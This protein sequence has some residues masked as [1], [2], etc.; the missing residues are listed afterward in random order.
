MRTNLSLRRLIDRWINGSSG[1][2]CTSVNL[3]RLL[4]DFSYNF[5]MMKSY[6]FKFIIAFVSFSFLSSWTLLHPCTKNTRNVT[7]YCELKLRLN[8]YNKE[9]SQPPHVACQTIATCKRKATSNIYLSHAPICLLVAWV[10]VYSWKIGIRSTFDEN[11]VW[12]AE[13]TYTAAAAAA[14]VA[15]LHHSSC[16]ETVDWQPVVNKSS[17]TFK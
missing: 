5:G 7:T 4:N 8:K 15:L 6:L 14:A 10:S 17:P 11:Y 13:W 12:K 2:A 1:R 3:Q 16:A 9:R